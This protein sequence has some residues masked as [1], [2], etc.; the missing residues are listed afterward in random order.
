ML[1][2]H[3]GTDHNLAPAEYRAQWDLAKTYPIVAAEYAER[4]KQ[5]A[6]KI[7]LGRKAGSGTGQDGIA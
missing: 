2:R 7:G 1:M 6:L 3:L 5:L 4:R